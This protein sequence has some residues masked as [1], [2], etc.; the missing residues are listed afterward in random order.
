MAFIVLML[1]TLII[2]YWIEYFEIRRSEIEKENE[3]PLTELTD[4]SIQNRLSFTFI[5]WQVASILLGLGFFGYTKYFWDV[6]FAAGDHRF[7]FHAIIMHIIWALTWVVISLPLLIT[8]FDWFKIKQSVILNSLID[9]SNSLD[10][11]ILLTKEIEPIGFW[12][13]GISGAVSI[14]S[15][16]YPILKN[17]F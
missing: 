9:S 13:I 4:T 7:I 6:V 14:I 8:Q 3:H 1:I 16:F 11:N 12:N 10:K 15:F 17:L 2:Y 5:Q